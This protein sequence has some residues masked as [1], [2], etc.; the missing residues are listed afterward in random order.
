[1]ASSRH[2]RNHAPRVSAVPTACATPSK[3]S[4]ITAGPSRLRAWVIPLDVGTC[5]EASQ[6]PNRD[7]A[8]VTFVATSV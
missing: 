7:N 8:P 1:M 4:A 6:H 3:T 2:R 5:Q